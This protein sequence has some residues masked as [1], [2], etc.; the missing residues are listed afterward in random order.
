M[1]K[2]F[3]FFIEID[4]NKV[5]QKTSEE[6]QEDPS[7]HYRN[8]RPVS[9]TDFCCQNSIVPRYIGCKERNINRDA[10]FIVP[11]VKAVSVPNLMLSPNVLLLL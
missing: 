4:H 5:G 8:L 10:I 2:I 3:T 7:S 6:E 11:A 9:F 1:G